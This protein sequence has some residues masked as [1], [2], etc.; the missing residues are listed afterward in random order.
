MS[1]ETVGVT[2][3]SHEV[4]CVDELVTRYGES[5]VRWTV[6]VTFNTIAEARKWIREHL[7]HHPSAEVRIRHETS[8]WSVVR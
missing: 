4:F 6:R 1:W 3:G 2:G 8:S 5:S 7:Q